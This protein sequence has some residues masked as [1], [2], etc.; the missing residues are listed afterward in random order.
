MKIAFLISAYTDPRQLGNMVRALQDDNHWFFIHV[1]K[2]VDIEP[3]VEDVNRYRHISF[4]TNRLSVNWGGGYNQ[5]LYQKELLR[6]CIESGID[7]DRVFILT[8][9][10]YPLWSKQAI[11][12]ELQANPEKEYILGLDI[13]NI[14]EPKKIK[15]KLVLYHFFRDIP[16]RSVKVKKM[17]SGGSRI[18]MRML[19]F[20]KKPYLMVNGKRWDVYQA[21]GYMCI[22][23]ALARYLYNEMCSNKIVNS[24]F[25]HSFVPEEMV[26]PTIV[27]NSPY[28]DRAMLYPYQRY[29]GLK[30]LSAITYFNY[31][32]AIQV[33][34][35]TNYDELMQSGKMFARKFSSTKS[36][37]LMEMLKDRNRKKI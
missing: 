16:V 24:Y 17:F 30:S 7:F 28:R 18:I 11:W 6:S 35:E 31:G 12:D 23:M 27:Y 2:K 26:I 19:P 25:I 3:F 29:D 33:F 36:A 8:T 20:R 9:Q 37:R 22:T 34:D 10:D 21:S 15:D 13:T 1:D 5:V 4:V 32:K 14:K